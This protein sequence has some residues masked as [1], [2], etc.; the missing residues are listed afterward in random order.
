L[1]LIT[2]DDIVHRRHTDP[3][4]RSF[5]PDFGVYA[6]DY[7]DQGNE[8]YRSMS[9]QMVIYVVERRKAWRMLQSKAGV[10]SDDYI[11]QK[12]LLARVDK[13]EISVEEVLN[14]SVTA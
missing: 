7:D 6:V 14:G 8:V 10:T 11:K 13:G 2:M 9:R 3:S 12:E 5:I 1:Y 4:H